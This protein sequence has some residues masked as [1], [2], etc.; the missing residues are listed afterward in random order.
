[1]PAGNASTSRSAPVVC[2]AGNRADIRRELLKRM[3]Q[4]NEAL[5]QSNQKCATAFQQELESLR[6]TALPKPQPI[7]SKKVSVAPFKPLDPTHE[8]PAYEEPD[9]LPEAER[10]ELLAPTKPPAEPGERKKET[11]AD[12]PSPV[13]D[14]YA[15][16]G[17]VSDS[18]QRTRSNVSELYEPPSPS[19]SVKT[20]VR[21]GVSELYAPPAEKPN[22][23]V[24]DK[25]VSRISETVETLYDE[26]R[27]T[28]GE[29]VESF[30]PK[31]KKVLED[32]TPEVVSEN[33]SEVASGTSSTEAIDERK[34]RSF[35]KA[36]LDAIVEGV[37]SPPAEEA[38]PPVD[39]SDLINL[40]DT[41]KIKNLT[42]TKLRRL[43]A[44]NKL[45]TSGRKAELIARL[46]SYAKQ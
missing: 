14:L 15:A 38:T 45:K 32:S 23:S 3:E 12:I 24:F 9:L 27:D 20:Q 39:K 18:K 31:E 22:G 1:M 25:A 34:S 28:I 8:L 37:P 10:R 13:S 30:A 44:A 43:L 2:A 33:A 17:Q 4:R 6:K 16:S 21:N 5:K 35:G 7:S 40:V 46:T 11:E 36:I 29:V 42:V 41:G 19:P 26:A